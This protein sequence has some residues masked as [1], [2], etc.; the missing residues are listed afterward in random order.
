MARSEEGCH[1]LEMSVRNGPAWMQFTRTLGPKACAKAMVRAFRPALAAAYGVS[2]G[3]G[4]T[5]A[6]LLTLMIEPPAPAAIRVPT[7]AERRKGP[8]KLTLSTLSHSGSV[9][10]TSDR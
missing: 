10:S 8:F 6:M 9:T 3:V 4:R 1:A 7:S 5:A 2:T